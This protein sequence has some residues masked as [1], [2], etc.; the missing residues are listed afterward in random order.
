MDKES[1]EDYMDIAEMERIKKNIRKSESYFATTLLDYVGIIEKIK[2]NHWN[3]NFK[4]NNLHNLL[5]K[6]E[7]SYEDINKLLICHEELILVLKEKCKRD[8]SEQ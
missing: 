6:L 5:S 7:D 2:A 8:E 1:E 4:N 3:Y